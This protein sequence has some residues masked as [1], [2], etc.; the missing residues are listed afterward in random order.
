M[1]S[2][3]MGTMK[4]AYDTWSVFSLKQFG[5]NMHNICRGGDD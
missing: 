3:D 4:N 1:Q 2:L 5:C